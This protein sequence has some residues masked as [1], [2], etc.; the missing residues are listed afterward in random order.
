MSS[1]LKIGH[2]NETADGK[3]S[4]GNMREKLQSQVI[5]SLICDVLKDFSNHPLFT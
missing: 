3:L 4:A 2:W 5:S 1:D